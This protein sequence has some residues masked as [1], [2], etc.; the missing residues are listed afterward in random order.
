MPFDIE[1][2]GGTNNIKREAEEISEN[3]SGATDDDPADSSIATATSSSTEPS[4]G[5]TI[6]WLMY[7]SYAL[8]GTIGIEIVLIAFLCCCLCAICKRNCTKKMSYEVG[9]YMQILFFF[10]HFEFN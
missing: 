9:G 4:T 2:D 6:P 1:Y 3:G 7:T 5:A 8:I 10:F